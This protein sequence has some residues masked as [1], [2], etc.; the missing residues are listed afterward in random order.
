MKIIKREFDVDTNQF[1]FELKKLSDLYRKNSYVGFGFKTINKEFGLKL[2]MG[3]FF[4]IA[5]DCEI[6]LTRG[7]MYFRTI[8]ERFKQISNG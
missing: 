8:D 7:L 2:T 1:I 4:Q 3:D 5:E 6:P